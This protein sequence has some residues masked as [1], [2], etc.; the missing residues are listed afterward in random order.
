MAIHNIY[1]YVCMD[2]TYGTKNVKKKIWGHMELEHVV[3]YFLQIWTRLV[4]VC[5]LLVVLCY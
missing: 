4:D 1:I 2:I 3:L 5:Q